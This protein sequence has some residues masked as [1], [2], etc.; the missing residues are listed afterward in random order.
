MRKLQLECAV[1]QIELDAKQGRSVPVAEVEAEIRRICRNIKTDIM[2]LVSSL[3]PVLAG[4][5]APAVQAELR[6]AIDDCLRHLA[7]K[8]AEG[9]A[10]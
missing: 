9:R 3:P 5:D 1:L 10:T 4:L 6:K 7:S 8:F 2:A